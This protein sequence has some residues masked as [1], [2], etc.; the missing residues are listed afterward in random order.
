MLKKKLTNIFGK[1][2]DV[3]EK[4]SEKL[5][6]LEMKAQELAAEAEE[7]AEEARAEGENLGEASKARLAEVSEKL[8]IASQGMK[9]KARELGS[10]A[11]EIGKD[12]AAGK[13]LTVNIL[14]KNDEIIG[15]RGEMIT[16]E[17][18]NRAEAE[19]KL[20]FVLAHSSKQPIA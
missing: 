10:K 6:E 16:Y 15:R 5:I 13:Y 2:H 18:L 12:D 9:E 20:N 3:V 11:L 1:G 17:L 14:A 8:R 7:L 4:S 19:G